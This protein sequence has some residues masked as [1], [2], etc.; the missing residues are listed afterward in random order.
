MTADIKRME[1]VAAVYGADPA[2]WPPEERARLEAVAAAHPGI[3]A[4]ARSIDRVLGRATAPAVPG[5]GPARL[6][7]R[8]APRSDARIVPFE[9]RRPMRSSWAVA[10][11]LAA[12]L[13]SGVYLG[14][15]SE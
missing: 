6:A 15:L 8:L 13:A 1:E 9:R 7:A 12:S 11:A 10:G 3:L 14:T 4:D 5:D 2:R